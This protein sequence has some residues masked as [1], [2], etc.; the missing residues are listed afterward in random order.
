MA[1]PLVAATSLTIFTLEALQEGPRTES[2]WVCCVLDAAVVELGR[3][4]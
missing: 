4:Q 1:Q 3:R 2:P